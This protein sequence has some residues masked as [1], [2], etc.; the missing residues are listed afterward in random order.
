[1][2]DHSTEVKVPEHGKHDTNIKEGEELH[3]GSI[4]FNSSVYLTT[5]QMHSCFFHLRV[6]G[7]GV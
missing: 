4:Y 6:T 1:M 5:S 7:V 2:I 3:T